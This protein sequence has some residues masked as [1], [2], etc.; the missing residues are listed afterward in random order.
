[1]GTAQGQNERVFVRDG[2]RHYRRRYA[3]TEVWIGMVVLAGLVLILV[4]VGWKGKHPDPEIYRTDI[5]GQT[6]TA[7][8]V[9]RTPLPAGLAGTGWT[10]G[11]V[12]RF[13]SETLYQKINGR[14]GY[15]KG[16]GFQELVFVSLVQE[17]DPS[18]VIDIELFDQGSPEN[19]G[20]AYAGEVGEG[21][22]PTTDPGGMSHIDRN[23]LFLT[24]GRFYIRVIGSEESP[25]VQAELTRLRTVFQEAMA[26]TG[27]VS[28]PFALFIGPLGLDPG[29]VTYT[30]ENAFSF[31]FAKDVYSAYLDDEE[32]EI[33][34]VSASGTAEAARLAEQYLEG[35]QQ[36]GES[37]GNWVRDRYLQTVAGVRATGSWVIGVRGAPGTTE[38]EA[39][40]RLLE[41]AV[42][43]P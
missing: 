24:R 3:M 7:P 12:S 43:R 2:R 33:F 38:A 30:P 1:M 22:T 37:Q 25:E 36:Y 17:E 29:R 10:E 42:P 18:R 4:W 19:A 20:G 15:Y 32:T 21:V 16:F 31:G 41:D 27:V 9:D 39:A 40:L 35:F 5:P 14:E 23:A 8:V 34:V 13:D 11:T 26:G 6:A 28:E